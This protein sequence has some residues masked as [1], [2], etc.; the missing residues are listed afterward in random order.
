MDS[1]RFDAVARAA[2]TGA[3]RRAVLAA[4]GTALF[5]GLAV[6]TPEVGLTAKRGCKPRCGPC[7]AC[8]P[9]KCK[10]KRG[11]KTCKRGVCLLQP[12]GVACDGVGLCLNGVCNADPNCPLG[13]C[14]TD[15]DCCS[16]S[17][18]PLLSLRV[19]APG[20]TGARCSQDLN[21][22]SESCVGFRC[23]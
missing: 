3:P 2:L 19:C 20:P 1:E 10:R 17:C 13:G 12:D 16:G 14:Q 15:S 4:L 9:G 6:A 21:C 8:N 22:T 11:K 5:G 7:A 23:A 18:L